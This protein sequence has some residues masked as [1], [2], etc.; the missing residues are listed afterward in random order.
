MEARWEDLFHAS[1]MPRIENLPSE[2]SPRG[3]VDTGW[4]HPPD[5]TVAVAFRTNKS[6]CD[7]RC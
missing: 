1:E 5:S 7:N 4:M 3:R 6:A 2:S